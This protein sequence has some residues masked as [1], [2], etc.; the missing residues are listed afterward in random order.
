M[1]PLTRHHYLVLEKIFVQLLK[2]SN[3]MTVVTDKMSQIRFIALICAAFPE[4]K[5]I[6]VTRDAAAHVG[7]ITNII[8]LLWVWDIAIIC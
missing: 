5:I 1:I 8:S 2:V 4:A 3:E 7:Q 6:H